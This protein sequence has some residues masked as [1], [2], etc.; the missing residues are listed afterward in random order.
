MR[1]FWALVALVF[2]VLTP[3]P[4][5]IEA[6]HDARGYASGGILDASSGA[7]TLADRLENLAQRLSDASAQRRASRI[8]IP[9]VT[10]AIIATQEANAEASGVGSVS[11]DPSRSAGRQR[12]YDLLDAARYL[13][14][15]SGL[16]PGEHQ[17]KLF[18]AMVMT[19]A[20][21]VF[22]PDLVPNLPWLRETFATTK[23]FDATA[24]QYPR[25]AGKTVMQA[26]FA[27]VIFVSQPKG[28]VICF[29]L[30]GRQSRS[31]LRLFDRFLQCYAGSPKWGFTETGRDSRE[32]IDI[33]PK[34][35]GVKVR[36]A[37]FPGQFAGSSNNV[38]G[39]GEHTFAC[40]W[41]EYEFFSP[42]MPPVVL[43]VLANDAALIM[44]SSIAPG[45]RG[46]ASQIAKAKYRDGEPAV[47]VVNWIQAC[48]VCKLNERADRC[49]HLPAR[50]QHFQS[51]VGYERLRALMSA[52]PGSFER[53]LMN[54]GDVPRNSPA[55]RGTD[56]MHLGDAQHFY[57]DSLPAPLLYT[58]IDPADGGSSDMV[59]MTVAFYA[60][61]DRPASVNAVVRAILVAY[62]L[63]VQ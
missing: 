53:E 57:R 19:V 6:V 5:P 56:V 13:F 35:T 4:P 49:T 7:A 24:I 9:R 32:W 43:P 3:A 26:F 29:N 8:C 48:S 17:V 31:W 25:R 63:G 15:A 52:M 16:V 51:R 44:V 11:L 22:G 58:S 14:A 61:Y 28:N 36:A 12:F 59:V 40:F 38:R 33:I 41:D 21:R 18:R 46:G 10:Q 20:K 45:D 62:M 54:I 34:H 27:A 2:L 60:P 39:M 55:F 50:P 42:E 23:L 1:I 30:T 37:A 47:N